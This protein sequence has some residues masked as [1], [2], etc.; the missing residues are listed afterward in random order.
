MKTCIITGASKGIGRAIAVRLSQHDDIENFVLIARSKEA[1]EK[2]KKLMSP[3]KNVVIYDIDLLNPEKIIETVDQ[4]G[5]KFP[6]IDMLVNSAGFVDPK[7][8]L[9]TTIENWDKTFKINVTA[10]FLMIRESVKY[11]KRTGGKIINIA[12]TAGSTSRPGWLAYAA[13]KASVISMSKTL[14]DELDEYNIKVFCLSPGRCATDLRRLLAPEEDPTTIMQ[15]ED[16][17]EFVSSIT[18]DTGNVLDGQDIIVRKK[19]R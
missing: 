17:A 5:R 8:L 19:T 13:S 6:S 2:T 16:V 15:P 7:S 10:M 4:V 14:S 3:S 12:S 9:E 18:T 1:L 11:M